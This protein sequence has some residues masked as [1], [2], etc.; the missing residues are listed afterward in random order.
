MKVVFQPAFFR[1]YDG[2]MLVLRGVPHI[3]WTF[4]RCAAFYLCSADS[5]GWMNA[6][7]FLCQW[8]LL[9]QTRNLAMGMLP[10]QKGKRTLAGPLGGNHFIF[11]GDF[12]IIK[13]VMVESVAIPNV[14]A[15]PNFLWAL[16]RTAGSSGGS[17]TTGSAQ[18]GDA[19][20]QPPAPQNSQNGTQPQAQPTQP[21]PAQQPLAEP[22][23]AQQ[24]PPPPP[25]PPPAP[26]PA[27]PP[28]PPAPP[29]PRRQP[30]AGS[31]ESATG[32]GARAPITGPL[33]DCHY[34]CLGIQAG[35]QLSVVWMTVGTMKLPTLEW[36]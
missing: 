33:P 25:P 17:E 15:V 13:F 8:A 10:R 1:G 29:P 18:K 11:L 12:F 21:P 9:P 36:K 28:P 20:Q 23:P 30:C 7:I 35:C 32:A 14:V 2:D 22:Q 34:Q 6:P 16:L 27:P 31:Q 5:R 19:T 26:A 24:P 4:S 3:L